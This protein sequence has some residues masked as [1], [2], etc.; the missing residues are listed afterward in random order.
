MY[1]RNK[2]TVVR[3]TI[4]NDHDTKI[5]LDG[6]ELL[7][8]QAKRGLEEENRKNKNYRRVLFYE[9]EIDT[10]KEKIEKFKNAYEQQKK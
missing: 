8:I 5:I 9:S 4:A 6:L 10:L 3:I 2:K 1:I 7:L